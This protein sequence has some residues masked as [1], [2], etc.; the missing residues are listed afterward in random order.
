MFTFE[1]RE[2]TLEVLICQS[3]K[4]FPAL[5]SQL[6][7]LG[8]RSWQCL[9][10]YVALGAEPEA[11]TRRPCAQACR[12]GPSSFCFSIF[13]L[14]TPSSAQGL[15]G[16]YSASG[17]NETVCKANAPSAIFPGRPLWCRAND[18]E[19]LVLDHTQ[20]SSELTLASVQDS[21]PRGLGD[22]VGCWGSNPGWTRA[23]KALYPP[24]N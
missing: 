24:H 1:V 2:V 21:L 19:F 7:A 15:P 3:S 13:H 12:P 18:T 8:G 5:W 22:H 9:G 10:S 17:E 16:S 11:P 20:L 4:L 23:K 6:V 14:F